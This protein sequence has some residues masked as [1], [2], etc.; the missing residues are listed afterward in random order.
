MTDV[1]P[2]RGP[3]HLPPHLP[4]LPGGHD[5]LAR[6]RLATA[7]LRVGRVAMVAAGLV[8]VGAAGYL[9]GRDDDPPP[10]RRAVAVDP[11]PAR[12]LPGYD[13]LD[14][15]HEPPRSRLEAPPAARPP[16]A[17]PPA[18]VV[19]PTAD[20]KPDRLAEQARA[21]GPGG[22]TRPTAQAP[23]PVPASADPASAGACTVPAGTPIPLV[24]VNRVVTEQGG[25][26]VARVTRDVWDGRFACRAVPAGSTVTLAVAPGTA[27]GQRR[28]AVSDPVIYRPGSPEPLRPAAIGADAAGAAGLAG[29]VEVPWAAT[30]LLVA[31]STA[32]D[33]ATAALSD[34]GLLGAIL[35][36]TADRP[37]DQ[38]AR[39]QLERLPVITLQPGAEITL[40]LAE[41]L[42]LVSQR[43]GDPD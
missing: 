13:M 39:A 5:P 23:A 24:T 22:W 32:L 3:P 9:A 6:R 11:A 31:A 21:A 16:A 20:P 34:G 15:R 1:P 17:R 33:L 37:L 29:R 40:L 14:Q 42:T 30:G 41:P 19:T 12:P 8:A 2:D 35:G 7:G 4:P 43:I 36:R 27:R 25:V 18:A 38:A 28:I 26:L 10:P